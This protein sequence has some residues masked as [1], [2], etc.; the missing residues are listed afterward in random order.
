MTAQATG[1]LTTARQRID[2]VLVAQP[3]RRW[4]VSTLA[5]MLP[6]HNGVKA[7]AVR[8]TVNLLLAPHF[9]QQV[10]RHRTLTVALTGSGEQALTVA[11]RRAAPSTEG[12]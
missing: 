8:D 10:P 4:T 11:L 3:K 1:K 5:Q 12:G 2:A 7:S 6:A 9:L